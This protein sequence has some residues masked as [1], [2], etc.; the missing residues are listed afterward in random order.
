MASRIDR[1]RRNIHISP[2]EGGKVI[3]YSLPVNPGF[4]D[5]NIIDRNFGVEYPNAPENRQAEQAITQQVLQDAVPGK[6]GP[7]IARAGRRKGGLP[8]LASD[9]VALKPNPAATSSKKD[10]AA[11]LRALQRAGPPQKGDRKESHGT[12]RKALYRDRIGLMRV[13]EAK[14][15]VIG[16]RGWWQFSQERKFTVFN[17]DPGDRRE[18][19]DILAN[20]GEGFIARVDAESKHGD[21]ERTHEVRVEIGAR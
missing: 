6:L 13:R 3:V 1:I 4:A 16:V 11:M 20:D 5:P 8:Q 18:I 17:T 10:I 2:A 14:H 9:L 7:W 15:L 21:L 12:I 19:A